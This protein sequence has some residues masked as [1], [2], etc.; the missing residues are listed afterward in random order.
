MRSR[1]PRAERGKSAT[2]VW[3]IQRLALVVQSGKY[4]PEWAGRAR[5]NA[6]KKLGMGGVAVRIREG[7]GKGGR[8]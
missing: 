1:V 4:A 5:M 6:Q 7:G 3:V 2:G 8:P